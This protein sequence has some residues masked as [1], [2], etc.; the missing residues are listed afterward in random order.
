MGKARELMDR[1][2]EAVLAGDDDALREIYDPDVEITTPDAGRLRGVEGVVEWNRGFIDAF[3]ERDYR[4]E[5]K[6]ETD[7]SAIDQGVF[8]GVHTRPLESP[9]GT[10]I[11]PTGRRIEI[12][13]ADIATVSDDRIVRHDFY[14]DQVELLT[15][16]GLSEGG[17]PNP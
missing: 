11:P 13:S 3:S 14:F 9:D 12:R 10:S 8:I 17:A 1:V 4:S 15:Q 7:D 5:Q 2:T 6:F 16:L